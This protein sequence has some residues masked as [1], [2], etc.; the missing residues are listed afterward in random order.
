V[1]FEVDVV[2]GDHVDPGV[3]IGI[4]HARDGAGAG[5]GEAVLRDAVRLGDPGRSVPPRLPLVGSR[6]AG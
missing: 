4:V 3:R 5:L 2:P 1:G 6:M